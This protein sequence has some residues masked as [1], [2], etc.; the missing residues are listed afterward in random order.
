MKLLLLLLLAAPSRA[1]FFRGLSPSLDGPRRLYQEGRYEQV[2]SEL[3]PDKLSRLRPLDQ[4]QGYLYL[5]MAHERLGALDKALG[6]YQLGVRL[7]PKDLNLLTNL[8]MLLHRGGLEEQAEP[9]FQRVLKIHPNNAVAHLGLAEIDA[10]LGLYDS[11]SEHYEKSLE[12][13]AD[14]PRVWRDYAAV[15][16]SL[17]DVKTAE[18]AARKAVSLSENADG[19]FALGR[20]QRAAGRLD[21]ALASLTRA[22]Q[23]EPQ[24]AQLALALALWQLEAGKFDEA[25]AIADKQAS[26]ARPDPLAFWVRARVRLKRDQY[27]AA[28]DDLRRVAAAERQAP[29]AAAAAKELLTQ[30]EAR[31]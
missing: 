20:T 4:R 16:L 22:V 30:L 10:S 17:R 3:S 12:T 9:V 13:M 25:F 27:K 19:L 6:V 8:G 18:L 24:R 1:L 14:D 21:E 15:L 28:V 26:E 11:S 29:F 7:F 5:G 23:L 2:V 31:R